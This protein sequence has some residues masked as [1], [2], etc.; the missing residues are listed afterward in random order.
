MKRL[1][2]FFRRDQKGQSLVE[3]AVILP[4]LLILLAGVVEVSNLAVIQNKLNTAARAGARF[5]ANGGENVG[6]L[7]SHQWAITNTI[8]LDESIWDIWVFR[9]EVDELRQIPPDQFTF[10]H[11]YGLGQTQKYTET[12][13]ITFTNQLRQTIQDQLLL[14]VDNGTTADSSNVKFVGVYSLHDVQALLGLNVLPNLV[15]L[16]TM[17]G[18]SVMRR[19][20]LSAAVEQT[21]GCRGVFP[22]AV[23]QG[24]R[25][26][27]QAEYEAAGG[28]YD[29]FTYPTG[30][31]RPTWNE[32]V[33]Q[34][35]TGTTVSLLDGQEGMVYKLGYAAFT[36]Q[37]FDWLKWN[38]YI[39]GLSS[40]NILATSLGWPGNSDDYSNHNDL[41]A[42]PPPDNWGHTYRGFAEVGDLT[43]KEMHAGDPTTVP[44][45][46]IARDSISDGFGGF[47]V[48]TALN[49]HINENR[50]LR[51][52]SFR[53][54]FSRY[55]IHG[56]G[57]WYL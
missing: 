17:R 3:T 18:F 12:S 33:V 19:A 45:D 30:L 11:V 40:G 22:F 6:I 20:A 50:T 9:G 43:D 26:L 31:N 15:G 53:R 44:G 51:M 54:C 29:T 2:N 55:P 7:Q 21:S 49:S 27:T 57:L 39:T 42:A 36:P 24:V 25:T 41:P 34:P 10:E 8:S 5:G 56:I 28:V 35:P 38:P 47:G 23:E 46:Y 52:G 1:I 4:I 48:T 14:D 32:F 16:E 37:S 13:T